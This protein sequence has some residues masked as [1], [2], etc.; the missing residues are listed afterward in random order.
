MHS[1]HIEP[2]LA[3]AAAIPPLVMAFFTPDDW[4]RFLGPLGGLALSIAMLGVMLA[5][6]RSRIKRED[7]RA[8]QDREDRDKRHKE[9]LD[10]LRESRGDHKAAMQQIMALT[11]ESIKA[12]GRSTVAVESVDRTLQYLTKELECRPCQAKKML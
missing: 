4:Q 10:E 9:Q 3:A 6:A 8:R 1:P 2:P 12:Q 7:E 11:A 5:F